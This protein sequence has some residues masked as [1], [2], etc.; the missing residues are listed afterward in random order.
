MPPGV[1]FC[2]NSDVEIVKQYSTSY[3]STLASLG[4]TLRILIFIL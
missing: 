2:I 3:A 1:C 4:Q